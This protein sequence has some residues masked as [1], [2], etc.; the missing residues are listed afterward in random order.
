MREIRDSIEAG[1]QWVTKEGVLTHESQRGTR[2]NI[3]DVMAHQDNAHRGGDQIIPAARR[4]MYAAQ[5]TAQPRF[6]EPV[7]LVQ[8]QCP[9]EVVGSVY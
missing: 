7:F 3:V 9:N 5:L 4:A 8:V 2:Y 6:Q 1:F